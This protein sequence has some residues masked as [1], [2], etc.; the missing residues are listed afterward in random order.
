ME[1]GP[2]RN[3]DLNYPWKYGSW[4]IDIFTDTYLGAMYGTQVLKDMFEH[5]VAADMVILDK[6]IEFYSSDVS[7]RG[8]MYEITLKNQGHNVCYIKG[9]SKHEVCMVTYFMD[10]YYTNESESERALNDTHSD[11]QYYSHNDRK[12][13]VMD[14]MKKKAK[15]NSPNMHIKRIQKAFARAI[16]SDEFLTLVRR[17]M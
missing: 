16:M 6:S 1:S 13:L 9:T 8:N 12:A 2:I 3:D 4:G 7:S 15:K 5:G 14:R 10:L 17:N 11:K